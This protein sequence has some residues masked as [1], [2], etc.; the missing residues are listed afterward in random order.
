MSK[1]GFGVLDQCAAEPGLSC[2][3]S[4]ASS[5]GN[6]FP[7]GVPL[8]GRGHSRRWATARQLF[9]TGYDRFDNSTARRTFCSRPEASPYQQSSTGKLVRLRTVIA[10]NIG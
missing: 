2:G 5:N 9:G 3:G 10:T 1:E 6:I 8:S 7:F 4:P